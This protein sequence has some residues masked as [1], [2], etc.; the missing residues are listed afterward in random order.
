LILLLISNLAH[1]KKLI[2]ES[3]GYSQI[4]VGHGRK[5]QVIDDKQF[6]LAR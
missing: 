2:E 5:P 6:V 1:V 3:I 4:T